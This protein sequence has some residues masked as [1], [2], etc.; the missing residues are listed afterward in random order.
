[1]RIKDLRVC[2]VIEF[3]RRTTIQNELIVDEGNAVPPSGQMWK[4]RRTDGQT[5]S[6]NAECGHIESGLVAGGW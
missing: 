1:L 2:S 6:G 5:D 4:D 3:R